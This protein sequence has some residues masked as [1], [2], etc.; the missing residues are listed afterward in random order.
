MRCRLAVYNYAVRK[1]WGNFVVVYLCVSFQDGRLRLVEGN[2]TAGHVQV[3]H[4]GVWGDVCDDLWGIQDATVVCGQLFG[5]G[6]LR[7]IL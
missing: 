5:R 2:E 6:A 7:A 1:F 3:Y 4:E